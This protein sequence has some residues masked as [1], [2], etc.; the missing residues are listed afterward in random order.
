MPNVP[1]LLTETEIADLK[2]CADENAY[3]VVARRI[4]ADHG[5]R[6]PD[7]WFP[8]V[9]KSGGIIEEL[10]VKWGNPNALSIK[11]SGA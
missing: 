8:L 6:Y 3:G 11:V 4:K 7:D 10:R 1:N 9:L 2:N 5:N